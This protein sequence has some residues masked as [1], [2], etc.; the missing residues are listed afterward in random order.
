M[1]ICNDSVIITRCFY[2]FL[3]YLANSLSI[4]FQSEV[5]LHVLKVGRLY[6]CNSLGILEKKH[7]FCL[8]INKLCQK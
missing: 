1:L 3:S 8:M 5:Y 2:L 4:L 6:N 7:E